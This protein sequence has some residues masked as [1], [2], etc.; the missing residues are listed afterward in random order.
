MRALLVVLA[1]V[2]LLVGV[3][4]QPA[5]AGKGTEIE[6]LAK[7]VGKF[8]DAESAGPKPKGLCVCQDGSGNHTL[9]GALVYSGQ[10]GDTAVWM[11]CAVPV[12]NISGAINGG[13]RCDTFE[14]LSK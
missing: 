4:T 6:Q 8:A 3:A 10:L 5:S 9:V 2:A 7:R 14:I 11:F 1:G 12:F 13:A